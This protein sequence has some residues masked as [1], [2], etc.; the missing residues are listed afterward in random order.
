MAEEKTILTGNEAIARGAYEAGVKV[1]AA[2]PGTPSTEI[3]ENIAKY[4]SIYSQ[5]SVNEKVAMEVASGASMT[6]VR[7]LVAMKHVGLNVAA[8]PF[9]TLAYTGV[10]AG[11]VVV[12]ADD[13]GMHSSQ[14]E[15][16]NRYYSMMAKIPMLE[17]SDSQECKDFLKEAFKI[18][19]QFDIPVLL[20]TTTR[21]SHSGSVVDLD[22]DLETSEKKPYIKDP[23]KYVMIPAYAQI[24]HK[25]LLERW[26]KLK[27]YSNKSSLNLISAPEYCADAAAAD[28][29][30]YNSIGIVTS[31]TC[32]QFAK[33]SFPGVSILKLGI[34]NPLPEKLISDFLKDKDLAVIIEEL[35]PFIQEQVRS[36][37]LGIEIIGKEFFPENGELNPVVIET[38]YRKFESLNYFKKGYEQILIE[39]KNSRI[40]PLIGKYEEKTF[41]DNISAGD[42]LEEI[43]K[44]ISGIPPRPPVLCAGCSHRAVFN[45]LK[46]LK[47]TVMGDI[48]CYTLAALP[49]L[50]SVDTTLC[51][52]AG[53]SQALGAEKADPAFTGKLVSVIGDSTFFHSGITSLI[54]NVFNKGTGLVLILDNRVTAMTGHQTNPGI[55]KTLMGEETTAIMPENIAAA[56]GVKNIRVINPYDTKKLEKAIKEELARNELSVII[57][58]QECVLINKSKKTA[59]YFINQETCNKCGL[60]IRFGCPAIEFK[61]EKYLISKAMCNSCGVCSVICPSK[62]IK[63][64]EY[65]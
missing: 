27:D 12:T 64:E 18:S 38:L 53:V 13:P 28:V 1:A 2:Y 7:A 63:P 65:E 35:S 56:V 34:P 37:N 39:T 46:K 21:I 8:D 47:L 59:G 20:R 29:N 55:G 57:C 19:E 9:M 15:Q 62:S 26:Q 54:D 52:G 31:G 43:K 58:R 48:G 61:S 5:W 14:N 60:C 33:E 6:G 40:S 44:I 41:F 11:I 49:P 4:K 24:R 30:Y 22:D 10:N 45:I 36:M 51:M 23:K 25:N 32:F 50:N 42:N 16:D 17:P 3:L